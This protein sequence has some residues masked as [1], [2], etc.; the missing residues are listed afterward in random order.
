MSSSRISRSSTLQ[1]YS[2]TKMIQNKITSPQPTKASQKGLFK[3]R[4]SRE[5]WLK[6]AI[7]PEQENQG[8]RPAQV[9]KKSL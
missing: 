3:N 7:L 2:K 9:K 1:S 6:P 4:S 5:C 8:L